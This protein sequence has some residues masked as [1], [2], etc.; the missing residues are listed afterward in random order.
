MLSL[1]LSPSLLV[2]VGCELLLTAVASRCTGAV[3]GPL[4]G[5]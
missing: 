3:Q 1:S 2:C 5:V 4:A